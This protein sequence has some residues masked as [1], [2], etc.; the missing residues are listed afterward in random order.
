LWPYFST[1]CF[2]G[3]GDGEGEFYSVYRRVFEEIARDEVEHRQR[4][5]MNNNTHHNTATDA[6][7]VTTSLFSTPPS[8]GSSHSTWAE[9]HRFYEWWLHF[10]SQRDFSW[11]DRYQLNKA[12][13]RKVRRLMEKENKKERERQRKAY[14]ELVR[15][16]V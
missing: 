3:W 9:V 12:P 13:N 5:T 2:K 15:V 11:A 16:C 1:S 6:V 14:N 4:V 10:A 8:F 7:T